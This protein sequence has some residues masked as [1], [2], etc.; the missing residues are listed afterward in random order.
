MTSQNLQI[1][2]SENPIESQ[3]CDCDF[4]RWC[5]NWIKDENV[6]RQI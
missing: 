5:D 4:T 1:T 3:L 2:S 6:H